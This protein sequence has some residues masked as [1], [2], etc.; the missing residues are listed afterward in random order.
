MP[1]VAE[2]DLRAA[3]VTSVLWCTGYRLDLDWVGVPLVDTDGSAVQQ[4]GVTPYP[5]L[6]LL[7]LHWMHTFRS[8]TFL[9]VGDDAGYPRDTSSVHRGGTVIRMTQFLVPLART[10]WNPASSNILRV[11]L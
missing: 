3:G 2:V 8:G 11:P 7:G 1:P 5:G 4:R 6:Y 9:G 10:Y